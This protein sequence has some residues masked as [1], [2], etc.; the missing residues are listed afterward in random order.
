VTANHLFRIAQEAVS[1]A[2]RHGK[3][4]QVRVALRVCDGTLNLHV[5]DDGRGFDPSRRERGGLGLELMRHRATVLGGELIIT[6]AP[7]CG[8]SVEC[9]VPQLHA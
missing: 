3:P 6:A 1:N 8:V 4:R 7:R 2:I 5:K 9:L